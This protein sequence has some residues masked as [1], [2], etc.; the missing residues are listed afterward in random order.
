MIKHIKVVLAVVCLLIVSSA[1][2]A[3]DLRPVLSDGEPAHN[4]A[5][6]IYYDNPATRQKIIVTFEPL[7]SDKSKNYIVVEVGEVEHQRLLD[8]GLTVEID[9]PYTELINQPAVAP[10]QS[11]AS[12]LA[13]NTIPGFPCY[14]TVEDTFTSAQAIV[15]NYPTLASWSDVGDTWEKANGF[16]GYDLQVLVLT[17]TAIAG[18]KP[19][20]FITS[21]IHAREYTPAELM[22]RFAEHLVS[23]YGSNADITWILDHHEVHLMLQT[24]PDGRK[25]AETGLL[26]RKNTNQNYCGV[27]SNTRGADLNRNFEFEWDCCGGSSN[28][29][30]STTYHGSGPASE[31]EAQAVQN[32]LRSHFIDNRGPNLTDAAPLDTQG[33]YLD[34]HSYSELI[35][36]PWGFTNTVAPNS[37]Q[38]QTLGRKFAFFNNYTPQQS[39]GLYPTDGTTTSFAYGELGLPAYTFELGTAFFQDCS[40]FENTIIPANMP[41][42]VYAL[43]S[44]RAPYRLPA[45]PET[46]SVAL[47]SGDLFPVASGTPVTVSATADDAR[48]NASNGTEPSQAIAAAEYFI[49]IPPWENGATPIPMTAVDGVFDS[50]SEV[51]QASINTAGLANG[52]HSVFIHSKDTDNSWGVVSAIFLNIDDNAGPP[53]V[54]FEDDFESDSGWVANP[55]NTDSATTGQWERANPE[56]TNSNGDKQ[57]GDTVSGTQDL[58]TGASAGASVGVNDIDNGVTSMRSPDIAIPA[59]GPFTLSFSYYMAHTNNSS[60]DDF[61][62]L[63]IVGSS[64]AVLLEESGF[65]DDDDAAWQ[66]FSTNITAFAGQT[67]HFLI[68]AADNA[69]G[70]IVEAGVDDIK[71]EGICADSD[72]DG[73]DDCFEAQIGTDPAL[74]DTDGDGVSDFDE[75]NFD[76]SPFNYNPFH[77]VTNPGGSDLDANNPDTD[78]D[79][80]TDLI[81]IT[82]G[83]NPLDGNDIPVPHDGDLN[84]DGHVNA[85]DLLIATRIL[86]GQISINAAQLAH[87][88]V[89]PLVAGQPAPDGVFTLGDLVVIQRKALGLISF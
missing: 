39:I 14:R 11:R 58:V 4:Y 89:A 28:D 49:D 32:Y 71:I 64:T 60:V 13:A 76:A 18:P 36:W 35:L 12:A 41:A 53:T 77:P 19:K 65:A 67:V 20:A 7:E 52:Q 83:S 85:V 42:L 40:T 38:L 81:E 10:S 47:D 43:K 75:V 55:S 3:T 73:L 44:L 30:C 79:G 61:F 21:S 27:T 9:Q 6:R 68:E 51:V 66:S 22:T 54:I 45:G 23:Q 62:R 69:G 80:Y 15:T 37:T 5:V 46:F 82:A 74:I 57:L 34:I 16:G 48:Y 63:S 33:L 26:W 87:G 29:Q 78:G 17:N 24:N 70:S 2:H 88:D 84:N 86:N 72:T 1:I 8:L 25:Q 50:G 56:P 31:P 59:G